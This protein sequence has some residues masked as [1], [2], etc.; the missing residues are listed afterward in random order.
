[1]FLSDCHIHSS[2]SDDAVNTMSE[3]AEAAYQNGISALCFTDHADDCLNAND[4]SYVPCR[5]LD[6]AGIYEEYLKVRDE[7]SGKLPI[8][9]GME[10]SGIEQAPETAE[11][12]K[13]L[14]PFDFIIGSA[15]NIPGSNDFF[16]MTYESET[17]CHRLIDDYLDEHLKMIKTGGFDVIGHICYPMKYMANFGIR[18]D[19]TP[20]W[21]KL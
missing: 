18:L 15:H 10:I 7:F 16:Y 5:F 9:F 4:I 13:S 20:H 14:Y 8:R 21:D 19:L 12:I 11:K 1:M 6:K 3:M 2:F 17:D